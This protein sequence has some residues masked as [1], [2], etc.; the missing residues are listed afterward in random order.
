M[1]EDGGGAGEELV[2]AAEVGAEGQFI[3]GLAAGHGEQVFRGK[4]DGGAAVEEMVSAAEVEPGEEGGSAAQGTVKRVGGKADVHVGQDHPFK[5]GAEGKG[6]L[7]FREGSGLRPLGV[8][9]GG[10]GL[11]ELE[12]VDAEPHGFAE[13]VDVT[14]GGES[15]VGGERGVE[16]LNFAEPRFRQKGGVPVKGGDA[17]GIRGHGFAHGDVARARPEPKHLVGIRLRKGGSGEGK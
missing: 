5:P 3:G 10:A 2:G 14:D 8:P 1:R 4:T 7:G 13:G 11:A 6:G 16:R 9:G 15:E 17:V 12:E